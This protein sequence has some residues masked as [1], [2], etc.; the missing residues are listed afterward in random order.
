M[1]VS[2]FAPRSLQK[3]L[4]FAVGWLC[5]LG[6]QA[7]MPTVAAFGSQQVL[8]LISVCDR[9]Y[10]QQGWHGALLTIA[11]V[12]LAII[13]NIAAIGQMPMFERLSMILHFLGFIAVI[14][15][16]WAL[17]PGADPEIAF[18]VFSDG[19]NWGSTGLATIVA[20]VGPATTFLGGDSAVHL[21]EELQDAS[22]VLPR[23]MVSAAAINYGLGFVSTVTLMFNL[24]SVA[25]VLADPSGQPWVAVLLRVTGSTAAT[26][27][28]LLVMIFM[29]SL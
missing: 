7:A 9:S 12:L 16:Y 22:Y 26:V 3:Q 13:F 1:Q 11:F 4:S 27:I 17:G 10:V 28:L 18:T 24:G 20:I 23:A 6:W 21:A 2:E 29:V 19:N 15:I 14:A 25:E 5:C 8:A